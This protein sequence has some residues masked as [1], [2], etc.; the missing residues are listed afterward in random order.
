[1]TVMGLENL[2]NPLLWPLLKVILENSEEEGE[3]VFNPLYPSYRFEEDY[4]LRGIA[5]RGLTGHT[6]FSGFTQTA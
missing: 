5:D 2:K 1:M 6:Q 3:I 4:E